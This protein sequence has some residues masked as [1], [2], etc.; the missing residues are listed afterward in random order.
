MSCLWLACQESFQPL[1]GKELGMLEPGKLETLQQLE[2]QVAQLTEQAQRAEQQAEQAKQEPTDGH[3]AA[4]AAS[5]PKAD[6]EVGDATAEAAGKAAD[7]ASERE[8]VAFT[9]RETGNE[10]ASSERFAKLEGEVQA[11]TQSVGILSLAVEASQSV[12]G[13]TQGAAE[14]G[15]SDISDA[16]MLAAATSAASQAPQSF[17]CLH[18]LCKIICRF[19]DGTRLCLVARGSVG[20]HLAH[21][22][23]SG[24]AGLTIR[25]AGAV[26]AARGW[27]GAPRRGAG[28]SPK[29]RRSCRSGA[30]RGTYRAAGRRAARAGWRDG[31]RRR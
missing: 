16:A 26:A 17:L 11:L 18:Y 15:A 6:A 31:G 13:G 23:A 7:A 8:A 20:L 29:A 10:A 5:A 28:G 4:A 21:L 25:G 2:A 1:L 22:P 19:I 27:L 9:A 24:E 14:S 3:T 12:P 30:A